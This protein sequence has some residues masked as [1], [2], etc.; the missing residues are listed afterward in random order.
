MSRLPRYNPSRMARRYRQSFSNQ[1][2]ERI[3]LTGHLAEF[4]EALE[5]EIEA[6]TRGAAANA[7]ALVNG[8]RIGQLAASFQYRF[9]VESALQMPD[10]SLAD[11]RLP[12][13][14][15]LQATLVSS[16]GM[17]LVLSVPSDL[18]PFVPRATL[19]TD[20]SILLRRLIQRV[21][22]RS[23]EQNPPGERLLGHR[24]HGGTG[25]CSGKRA[26]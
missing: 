17:S 22:S 24:R 12:D 6:A 4:R 7:V 21:E 1:P 13:G 2:G 18:G 14:A 19:V 23:A 16:E 8:H 20:L 10:D 5:Q 9:T 25:T 26:R 3:P 15:S 11:L